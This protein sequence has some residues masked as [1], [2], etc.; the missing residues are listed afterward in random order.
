MDAPTTIDAAALYRIAK[1][2][3]MLGSSN[4]A[5]VLT[6][7]RMIGKTLAAQGL[8]FTDA[9]LQMKALIEA[10]TAIPEP[11]SIPPPPPSPPPPPPGRP[12]GFSAAKPAPPKHSSGLGSGSGFSPNAPFSAASTAA[13]AAFAKRA[14]KATKPPPPP[15]HRPGPQYQ[16]ANTTAKPAGAAP[17]PQKPRWEDAAHRTQADYT[18]MCDEIIKRRAWK[19]AKERSFIDTCKFELDTGSQLTSRQKDWFHDIVNRFY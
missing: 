1:L 12:T 10:L 6:T 8:T 9:G 7:L 14:A 17:Q 5:E 11:S 15:H 2:V 19:N 18:A 13:A 4:D 16:K 3:P